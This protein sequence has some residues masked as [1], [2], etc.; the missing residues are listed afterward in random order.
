MK[1]VVFA[2]RCVLGGPLFV[3]GA[4]MPMLIVGLAIVARFMDVGSAL[5]LNYPSPGKMLA[6]AAMAG[7]DQLATVFFAVMLWGI[8]GMIGYGIM[9]KSL[10]AR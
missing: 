10:P 9:P 3:V 7:T 6:G 1:W 4:V 2:L 8:V 5:W